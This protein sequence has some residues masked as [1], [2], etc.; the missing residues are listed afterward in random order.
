MPCNYSMHAG[1]ATLPLSTRP[2]T[3]GA[4]PTPQPQGLT[5]CD[6]LIIG[7]GIMGSA[8]ARLLREDDPDTSIIM[9]DAGPVIGPHPGQH[10]H[11]AK[12]E[13]VSRRFNRRAA[14]GNQALYVGASGNSVPREGLNSAEPGMLSLS[15]FGSDAEAMPGASVA[16]NVGGM[17]AH[18]AVAAPSPYGDEVVN[19]IPSDE[20]NADLQTSK[21]L[22]NVHP[23]PYGET[24]LGELVHVALNDVFSE[25]SDSGRLVQ[26][27][28]M[29]ATVSE[30]G[31]LIRTG[32]SVIFPP[33]GVGGDRN[34]ELRANTL[35]T[36][37]LYQGSRVS[38]ATVR[39]TRSGDQ[40]TISAKI[41]VVCCDALRTPQLLWSSGIRPAALG[42]YL[43][44]HAFLTGRVTVDAE[45]LGFGP[46]QLPEPVE[47][48][49][50]TTASWLPYSGPA[51]PFHG[52][53]VQAPVKSTSAGEADRYDVILALYIPTEVVAENRVRFSDTETD[54]AGLPRMTIQFTY[55]DTDLKMI[56]LARNSQARAG[57]RLGNFDRERDSRVLPPGSSLHYTG[58]VRM[59][60]ANDG[61]SVCD[62]DTRVWDFENLFVAGNGVIPTALACNSTL[63]GTITAVRAA[64]A[65]SGLL[66]QQL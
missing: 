30:S 29:A 54:A 2:A 28:P 26:A 64:R 47:G 33:L 45:R 15:A 14:A 60:P 66:R 22:L 39:D 35:A 56:D 40:S 48:E 52:Q 37:L 31:A 1:G 11:D 57:E 7:S 23:S 13:A 43:N 41:T 46:I 32:P 9:I 8:V 12:D 51:Q 34:F 16:W 10:L 61:T 17:G 63:T 55:S 36:E 53:I 27:M 18:W 42:K 19:C 3:S 5:D 59:G 62:P 21:R 6:V 58:T 4:D 20:W 49:W 24:R 38:G 44:E 50:A 65:V 25:V